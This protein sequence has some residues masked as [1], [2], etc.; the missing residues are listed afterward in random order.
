MAFDDDDDEFLELE[1]FLMLG[2]PGVDSLL[3]FIHWVY[4]TFDTDEEFK[5]WFTENSRRTTELPATVKPA[6]SYAENDEFWKIVSNSF[7]NHK[8]EPHDNLPGA[9]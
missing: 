5:E 2:F 1:S 7:K 4:E 6:I 9:D 3:Q 8:E